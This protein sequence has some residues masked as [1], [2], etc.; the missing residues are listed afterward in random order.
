M[1]VSNCSHLT[2]NVVPLHYTV[3]LACDFKQ[4]IPI[5]YGKLVKQI[6]S[7]RGKNSVSQRY[8]RWYTYII[9]VITGVDSSKCRKT[10]ALLNRKNSCFFVK[11]RKLKNSYSLYFLEFLRVSVGVHV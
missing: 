9:T 1:F 10:A 4:I 5:C 8:S 6:S 2:V 11:V 7:F 3:L